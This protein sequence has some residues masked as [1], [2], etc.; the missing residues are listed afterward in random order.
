MAVKMGLWEGRKE[1]VAGKIAVV[2]LKIK[3]ISQK[4]HVLFN[5]FREVKLYFYP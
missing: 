4:R 5:L 3:A 1:G 2:N